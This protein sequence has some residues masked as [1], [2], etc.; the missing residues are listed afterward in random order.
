MAMWASL[1]TTNT[2]DVAFPAATGESGFYTS[3]DNSICA[4]SRFDENSVHGGSAFAG[5]FGPKATA[6][7]RAMLESQLRAPHPFPISATDNMSCSLGSVTDLSTDDEI[8][9]GLLALGLG[10]DE[11]RRDSGARRRAA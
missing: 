10:A 8:R 4:N 1:K 11:V 9:R 6:E 5:Y 7:T 2:V 3:P